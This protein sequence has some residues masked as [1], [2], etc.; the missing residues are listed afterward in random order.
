MARFG[1]DME[2]NGRYL[3]GS[4]RVSAVYRGLRGVGGDEKAQQMT[5]GGI[6]TA[7]FRAAHAS[8]AAALSPFL[9]RCNA[10]PIHPQLARPTRLEGV[11]QAEWNAGQPSAS[12]CDQKKGGR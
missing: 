3:R 1:S 5:F 2:H 12:V 4:R 11:G 7:L 10:S 6:S 8:V 9:G